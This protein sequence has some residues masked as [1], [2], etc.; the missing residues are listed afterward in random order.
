ME[1][2]IQRLAKNL[3]ARQGIFLEESTRDKV[4]EQ[5][6]ESQ[7]QKHQLEKAKATSKIENALLPFLNRTLREA[8]IK[9][10]NNVRQPI[11]NKDLFAE[12]NEGPENV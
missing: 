10:L 4:R 12:H 7:R 9:A 8:T 6:E 3:E 5:Y 11:F 2:S 1:T